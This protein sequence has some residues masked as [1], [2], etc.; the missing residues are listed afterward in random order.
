MS[1]TEKLTLEKLESI[2]N[3]LIDNKNR[4]EDF[5]NE[6]GEISQDNGYGTFFLAPRSPLFKV[7]WIHVEE[8]VV[9]SIGLGSSDS[10]ITLEQLASVYSNHSERYSI[11]DDLNEYVFYKAI[12]FSHTIKITSKEKLFKDKSMVRNIPVCGFQVT[13]P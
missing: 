3:F 6:F 12:P 8:N 9:N 11:Y 13:C 7:F 2:V 5:I 4:V 10:A 1:E